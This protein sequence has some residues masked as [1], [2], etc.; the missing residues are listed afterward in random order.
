[1]TWQLPDPDRQPE[2][3]RD[4]A[5]KR[6]V[7]FVIDTV[8]IFALSLIGVLLTAFTAL[9]FF[10]LLLAVIGFAYRAVTIAQRSATPGMRLMALEFR[11]LEG[12]RLDTRLAVLHTAGLTIS[13]L[14]PI[15]QVVSVILMLTQARGQGLSDL[16]LGTVALHRSA[17]S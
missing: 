5:P 3:Y 17:A 4:V 7:A 15:I 13:F 1:M 14:I 11:T 6:F 16:A 12:Q 8:I 9:F 10:P 2:F